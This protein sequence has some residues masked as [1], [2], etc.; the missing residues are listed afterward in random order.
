MTI[1]VLQLCA[2]DFSIDKF[3]APLCFHMQER[4]F[5][6]CAAATESEFMEPLRRRGLRCV[7]LP[8]SRSMDV[9]AHLRS[10][11]Q[12]SAWLAREPFDIVHVHT[13]IAALI[14][15]MAAWRRRVPIRIYTAHGFYFH[16]AM[17]PAKRAFHV[18]LE[19]FG[20]MLDHYLFTQSDEDR[21]TALRLGIARK[22]RALTIGNGIDITRFDPDRFD[23]KARR[24]KRRELGLPEEARVLAIIGR[25]VREKGYFELFEAAR[26]LARA[27]EDFRLLVIGGALESDYDDSTQALMAR[28]GELGIADRIVFAG[29]RKDVPECLMTADVFTLPSYREGMPRSVIEAMAMGLPVVATDIRGCRE[30]VV[31]GE[32]GY[33][34]PARQS[35]PLAA[36]CLEL[37]GDPARAARMGAAGRERARAVFDERLVLERQM[38]VYRQLIAERLPQKLK[39]FRG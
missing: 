36:C 9:G 33:L 11:R 1:K 30:E 2:V 26:E 29:P 16:E 7:D 8:I 35:G 22:G 28:V 39:D 24:A 25:L 14:G 20:G 10:Y 32:T 38:D 34:V 17:P 4:G 5:E 37:L 27:R 23:A 18:G 21:R 12:L 13:P 3:L 15:R 19:R 6:V 31:D